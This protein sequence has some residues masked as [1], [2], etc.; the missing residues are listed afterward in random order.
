MHQFSFEAIVPGSLFLS[1]ACWSCT[2]TDD[3]SDDGSQRQNACIIHDKKLACHY[4][5]KD[6]RTVHYKKGVEDQE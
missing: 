5:P 1:Y 3:A 2:A 4:R 6:T